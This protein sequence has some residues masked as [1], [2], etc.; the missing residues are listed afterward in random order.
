MPTLTTT[1]ARRF[2]AAWAAGSALA[3]GWFAWIVTAGS[4][5]LLRRERINSD[6]YESQARAL[7]H[8]RLSIPAQALN[9]EAFFHDGKAYTYF[10]PLPALF[11]IPVVAVTDR[12]D[13]RLTALSML[14]AFVVALSAIGMLVWRVRAQIGGARM[15]GRAETVAVALLALLVGVGT[16]LFFA[17][18]RAWVYHESGLWGAAFALCA[19]DQ[20]LAYLI[21]PTARRLAR[22]GAFADAAIL[23]RVT[24]GS[25]PAV[26]LGVVA[27]AVLAARLLPRLRPAVRRLGVS[28]AVA[29]S[30]RSWAGL[31]AASVLPV[32]G[33][34][35]VNW[36][37]FGTLFGVPIDQHAQNFVDPRRRRV[38][39]ANDGTLFSLRGIPT[40]VVALLRPDAVGFRSQ[41]PWIGVPE[42]R[43]TAFFGLL[44]DA[45]QPMISVTAAMPLI[46]ALAVVGAVVLVRRRTL[47]PLWPAVIGAA[48]V[49][50]LTWSFLYVAQRYTID[51]LPLM[52]LLA[53]PGF[54][55]VTETVVR[56][57]GVWRRAAVVVLA[58]V[59]A[60]GCWTGVAVALEY[61]RVLAPVV[62]D[63]LRAEYVDWQSDVGA[64]LGTPPVPV[65]RGTRLPA[66]A[67][68]NTVF[69]LGDCGALYVSDG[70]EWHGVE[71]TEAGG[72]HRLAVRIAPPA[73]GTV[74]PV[75]RVGTGPGAVTVGVRARADG[76]AVVVVPERG[77]RGQPFRPQWGRVAV[78]DVVVDDVLGQLRVDRDGAELLG[79]DYAGPVAPVTLAPDLSDLPDAHDGARPPPRVVRLPTPTPVCREV[80]GRAG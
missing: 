62:P 35:A 69:V 24:I 21:G 14:V 1:G 59:V 36:A 11:R 67:G 65:L 66:P 63:D 19:Y 71:R 13:G 33:Y 30:P 7:L 2:V 42:W 5:E 76:T 23:T 73:V 45:R 29:R 44:F 22:A 15:L 9:I 4:G 53:A 39:A 57:S 34:A 3:T 50:P 10:P 55:V 12:F 70:T 46:V 58:V 38:L 16:P 54:V 25:G 74:V 17:G 75:M 20:V 27:A 64:R 31:V 47:A 56:R 48:V 79:V 41:F 40:H 60:A 8:G 52:V 51:V 72:R 28:D 6:F 18:S 26:A 43:P 77:L 32:A 80:V 49:L 61:Q 78:F 37:K 68:R